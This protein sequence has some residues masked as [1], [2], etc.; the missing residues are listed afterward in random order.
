MCTFLT[1][2]LHLIS[3][4]FL[5]KRLTL[6][7]LYYSYLLNQPE[8]ELTY[9]K[10]LLGQRRTAI[11]VGAN[12]GYWTYKLAGLFEQVISIEMN[13]DCYQHIENAKLRNV[14]LLK[15]GLSDQEKDV[16][17]YLPVHANGFV[18]HG[19]GTVEANRKDDLFGETIERT[20][21]V[22]PL[23][24]YGFTSVDFIKIDVEGHELAVVDGAWQ[25]ILSNQPILVI[26]ASEATYDSLVD[27]LSAIGYRSRTLFE[28]TGV[29]GSA[30]NFVFVPSTNAA[31]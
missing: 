27:R 8:P 31:A 18:S 13:E 5:P 6:A 14:R 29:M 25:T 2:L 22:K 15:H 19:W 9:L 24:T 21:L 16:S 11:D 20:Y 4:R 17:F 1:K 3:R 12:V 10:H 7:G 26:E 28:L 23:D 30:E